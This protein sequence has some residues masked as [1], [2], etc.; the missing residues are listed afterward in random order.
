MHVRLLSVHRK[1]NT[2]AFRMFVLF[3]KSLSFQ[4]ACLI[5]AT[6]IFRLFSAI[7]LMKMGTNRDLFD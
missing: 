2:E 5:T 1:L 4:A 7:S 3:V 6:E